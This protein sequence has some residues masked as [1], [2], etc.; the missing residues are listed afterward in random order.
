MA[1]LK[2]KRI[3]VTGGSEGI[4]RAAAALAVGA[5]A[6]V[7]ITGRDPDKLAAAAEEIGAVAIRNDA[8]DVAAA[9]QLAQHV[10]ETLG[11]LDGC[12]FNAGVAKFGSLAEFDAASFDQVFDTNV[13]GLFFQAQAL[14]PV[15]AD[16][17]S[18]VVNTSVNNAMGMAGT[19]LYA[20][21]KGAARVLVRCMAGELAPRNIRVNAVSPGPVETP[22]YGKLGLPEEQLQGVASMLQTKIALG[23]FGR[24]EEIGRA[25]VF[26][27]S[28]DASFITGEELVADGGWTGVGG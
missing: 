16:G 27:L 10:Q 23:R 21:S 24:P 17:G 1:N 4:G 2:G 3:L 20:A 22:L 7:A 15:L 11:G 8:A 9:P 6:K 26:L 19:I 18:F 14:A 12:F 13:K 28:D 25:A 5:G